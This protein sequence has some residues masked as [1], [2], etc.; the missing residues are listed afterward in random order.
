MKRTGGLY[1]QISAW[2]NLRLATAKALRGKCRRHDARMFVARLEINLAELATELREQRVTLGACR[3]FVIHDPKQ[4]LITA[5]CFRDRVLHHA[6]MNVCEPP[7]ERFLIDDTFACRRGK[8]RVAAL[9]RARRFAGRFGYV[10]NFDIRKYFDSI[11]RDR[12]MDLLARRLKDR[13]LLQL[14]KQIIRCAGESPHGLPIGSLTSQH[15]ANFYL[16]WLDRFV[17]Q[18]LRANGYVRYMDDCA[19]WHD[20]AAHLRLW[21]PQLRGYLADALSLEIKP[22][23]TVKPTKVG[24]N[25]LGCRVFPDRLTLS[26]RSRRRFESKL[27]R[28]EEDAIAGHIDTA[29][30]QAR[31]TS[32]VAFTRAAGVDAW[33]FRRRVLQHMP[34]SGPELG[35]G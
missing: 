13:P 7:F 35:P 28:L 11:S 2:N 25:F 34:V 30:L 1:D 19:I 16:G 29:E 9:L 31:A 10:L 14:F 8:G 4:R 17:K 20:S 23:P 21:L 15:L 3:Q 33:G 27:R 32:L 12:L 24:L 26:R 6:I 18:T 22:Q 5:P